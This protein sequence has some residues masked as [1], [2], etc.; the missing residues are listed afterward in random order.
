MAHWSDFY[1][2]LGAPCTPCKIFI[3]M[4]FWRVFETMETVKIF[5][6]DSGEEKKIIPKNFQQMTTKNFK[7]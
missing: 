3:F 7:N 2:A 6:L 5:A 1:L 4:R